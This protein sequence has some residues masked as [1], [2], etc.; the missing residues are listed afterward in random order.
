MELSV[1]MVG[2]GIFMV[3]SFPGFWVWDD[4]PDNEEHDGYGVL[5]SYDG[6]T[7]FGNACFEICGQHRN[8]KDRVVSM[9]LVPFL[10]DKI[11]H[12]ANASR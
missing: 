9:T 6:K 4:Y 5:Y 11:R 7:V 12:E 8:E 10:R 2:W 3:D 1:E